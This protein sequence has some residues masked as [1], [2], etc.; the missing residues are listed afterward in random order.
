MMRLIDNIS[1]AIIFSRIIVSALLPIILETVLIV[2]ILPI[3]FGSPH[4]ECLHYL[5]IL[6]MMHVHSMS[7]TDVHSPKY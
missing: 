4:V 5:E 2:N 3:S 1:S 6:L 7:D